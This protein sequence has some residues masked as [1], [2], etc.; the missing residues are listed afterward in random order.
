M[1]NPLILCVDDDDAVLEVTQA[2]LARKG[3]SVMTS[4]DWRHAMELF[5]NQ[6][7]ALAILDYEMPEL[8]GHELAILMRNLNSE[9]PLLL[10]SGAFDVPDHVVKA[11]DGFIQ[12]GSEPN[13]LVAAI[14]KLII[15][16]PGHLIQSYASPNQLQVT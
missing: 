15:K 7:I 4:S 16:S 13:A 12:K 2:I 11:T 3:F 1:M 9:V 6:P 5:R 10:H 14:N 8:K